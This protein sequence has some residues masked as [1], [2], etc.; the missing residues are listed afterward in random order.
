DYTFTQL[1]FFVGYDFPMMLRVW[2]EYVFSMSGEDDDNSSNKLIGGSG[3]VLGIGYKVVPF[4]SLNFEISNLATDEFENATSTTSNDI[5]YTSYL[6]GI[7][8][9]I[10]L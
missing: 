4:V 9:P 8:F 7:S 6:L 5:S 10:S 3:T 2:G 1:S